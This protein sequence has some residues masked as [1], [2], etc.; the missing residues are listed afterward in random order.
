MRR[1]AVMIGMLAVTAATVTACGVQD[2]DPRQSV[3]LVTTATANEQAQVIPDEIEKVLLK[4]AGVRE[5]KAT[6][7]MP[8]E[9]AVT[10]LATVDLT[11]KRGQDVEQD[12]AR[13]EGGF[14]PTLEELQSTVSSAHS[15]AK[16][17][18]ALTGLDDAARRAEV[19]TI[20]VLSSGLQTRGL[21]DFAGLG[22]D[23]DQDQLL[24]GLQGQGFI[25]NLTDKRVYFVLGEVAGVQ[26]PLPAPMRDTV[27]AFWSGVCE[28]GKAADCQFVSA[29]GGGGP[30]ATTPGVKTVPVPTFELQSR[31]A[32]EG[33]TSW[34]L[35]TAALFSPDS[36]TLLPEAKKLIG[37]AVPKITAGSSPVD[38]VGHTAHFGTPEGARRLATE[39]ARAVADE[40]QRAGVPAEKISS[41]RG[42]GY[43]EPL[44]AAPGQ[45]EAAANR[46]VVLTT[47]R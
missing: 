7:L 41:V 4:S 10:E 30:A 1:A 46:A 13:R 18:D 38:I 45:D 47:T 2:P 32:P 6:V 11:V 44:A 21:A 35:D 26:A 20:V 3:F 40:L 27:R 28:R 16:D 14:A 19:S 39:R 42:V 22:W 24:D 29:A 23:F 17:L 31:P 36:A 34:S 33:R 25:P 9:G 12:A 5:A 15:K 37:E 8:V 43:D